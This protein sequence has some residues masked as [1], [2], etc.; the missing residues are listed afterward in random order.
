MAHFRQI[1]GGDSA[2]LAC[3]C[4]CRPHRFLAL[5]LLVSFVALLGPTAQGAAYVFTKIADSTDIYDTDPGIPSINAGGTVAFFARID[6]SLGGG[7]GIFRGNGGAITNIALSTEPTFSGFANLP[8]INTAG[9]VAFRASLD[10]GG[11][12]G[13]F[14]GS[15]GPTAT[16][17]LNSG[18]IFSG[19]SH[20]AINAAGTVAF[21]ADLDAGGDGIFTSNGGPATTVASSNGPVFGVFG[22]VNGIVSINPLGRVAF[23]ATL[24]NGVDTGVFTGSG[25]LTT[26]IALTSGPTFAAVGP[27]PSIN[28]D[29]MVAFQATLD[30]GDTG[31]FVG[32]GGVTTP[33]ALSSG[34]A[35]ENF[36]GSVS[37]N[38]SGTVAFSAGLTAGLPQDRVGIFTGPDPIADRVIAEEDT[39]F[40]FTVVNLRFG[41]NALNDVGQIAFS[42]QLMNGVWGIAVATPMVPEPNHVALLLGSAFVIA[43]RRLRRFIP[44]G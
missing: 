12:S 7:T 24:E 39:L 38:S 32:N 25:G 14:T 8:T 33:I 36:G 18:P 13:I 28:S 27:G 23:T 9:T 22:S 4:L 16:I 10:A 6:Q 30:T 44:E 42:Y 29:D 1:A 43:A 41:N 3:V 19:F 15:G 40:G 26:P 21:R 37:I 17:A 5:L 2:S 31:V 35:Y 34:G 11:A 20:P